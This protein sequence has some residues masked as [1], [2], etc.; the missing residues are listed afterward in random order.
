MG[1][2]IGILVALAIIVAPAASQAAPAANVVSG[3]RY[4]PNPLYNDDYVMTVSFKT[5]RPA[6][7]GYEWLVVFSISGAE[8]LGSCSSMM[9]SNDPK[10]GG[11]AR[12]HRR[13]AGRQDVFLTANRY[14][15]RFCKGRGSIFV[16]EH[17]IGATS[18]GRP[19]GPGSTLL[20]FRI[21][22]A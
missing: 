12:K 20:G 10:F 6:R 4:T 16:S 9:I 2:V 14:G 11:N 8:P 13:G 1:K 19:L 17:K 3:L 5:S 21:L 7:A 22:G 15:G 18:F